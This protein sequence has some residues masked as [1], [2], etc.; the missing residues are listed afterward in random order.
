MTVNQKMKR[1]IRLFLLNH[2]EPVLQ[3][4]YCMAI[5]PLHF[6]YTDTFGVLAR[7]FHVN[8]TPCYGIAGSACVIKVYTVHSLDHAVL[9]DKTAD[10]KHMVI[11]GH[12]SPHKDT[13]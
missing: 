6:V 10:F 9:I 11:Y 13:D 2:K 4:L 5:Y 8:R 7:A 3:A 1:S 12:R